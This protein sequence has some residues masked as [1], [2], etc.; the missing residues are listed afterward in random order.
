MMRLLPLI[1]LLSTLAA[2]PADFPLVSDDLEVKLFAREPLVRNPCAIAFDAKGRLC[3][4]MGPQYRTPKLE[5]AGDSVWILLDENHDGVAEGRKRFATGFNS[6]Q[7]LA[8]KNGRL[9]VANAP[10]LTVVRDIDGDEVADEYIR[11]YT[12]LGNLEHGLH[13]LNWAPDGRLYMSKGN[14][15]GLTQLPDRVAP[16]A[17]RELWG[18]QAPDAPDFPAPKIF[19]A[20]NY[21]KNYHDP[22]DD[23]GREGGIL[24]CDGNGKN[25]EIFSRGFRNPWDICF[26]DGFTWLGTDN[27]QT[28]GDKIFSPFY[29]A[30]F[31][32]GHPWSY[33]W[34]GDNH[35]P[36]VPAAGPLFEGSGTGVIFCSM[37]LWPKKYRGVFLINDW[38]RRQV[39]IFRP[40]WDGARLKPEKEKFDLFAHA[41]GGRTMGKSGGRSF[42]P[43]DIEVGPDGAVW[44]SSWGREYGAKMANGN[45]QNE[46]R[47]YRLWPKGVKAVFKPESKSAKPLKDW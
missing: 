47:I 22:A 30:H 44:I 35:L 12:D 13:G 24:R 7:G 31:G 28:H 15:K 5:T 34:K 21:Q 16:R 14:S 32:W 38:L 3:V 46:G 20:A 37:P 23:W 2:T 33:D 45:Q 25:L 11:L 8:W 27:D 40:K 1:L 39:Y 42:S 18:V 41:G 19:N 17:F 9:W 6:I 10:D 4:G 43:V 36:T 26:D 29:G